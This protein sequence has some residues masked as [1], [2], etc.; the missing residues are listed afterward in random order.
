M[1]DDDRRTE[2]RKTEAERKELFKNLQQTVK[3]TR[4]TDIS[5][6]KVSQAV[7]TYMYKKGNLNG[8]LEDSDLDGIMDELQGILDRKSTNKI[9]VQDTSLK[10]RIMANIAGG[11]LHDK[12]GKEAAALITDAINK[13]GV[14]DI[15]STF[16]T[17]LNTAD[18]SVAGDFEDIAT[19]LKNA[20]GTNEKSKIENKGA[21][22][23]TADFIKEIYKK[24]EE[25]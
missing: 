5:A 11:T 6:G 7:G 17:S 2:K 9:N 10:N 23:S 25:V 14:V 1:M 3:N 19:A 22:D 8:K 15:S 13:F 16:R 21:A 12:S 18:P 4:K 24:Y 20:Y